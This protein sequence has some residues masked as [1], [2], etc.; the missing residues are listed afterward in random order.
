M[1]ICQIA[2]SCF[3]KIR[4]KER[5]WSDRLIDVFC[6]QTDSALAFFDVVGFFVVLPLRETKQL[7]IN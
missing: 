5:R 7:R 4:N 6:L 2:H 1:D 3:W